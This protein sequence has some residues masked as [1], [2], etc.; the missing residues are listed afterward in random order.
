MRL[1]FII[2]GLA[3][4]AV[5]AS[6]IGLYMASSRPPPPAPPAQS[7]VMT[8]IEDATGRADE[9]D[10][11]I[12]GGEIRSDRFI[13]QGMMQTETG[14]VPF[15]GEIDSICEARD[16][17]TCWRLAELTL[18]GV[19]FR[20]T[21]RVDELAVRTSEE[22]QE[23][24]SMDQRSTGQS[25]ERSAG[26]EADESAGIW[27]TVSD[28]VFGRLSPDPSAAEALRMPRYVPLRLKEQRDAWGQFE[29]PTA[30]GGVALIW[31]EME[32]VVRK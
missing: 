19:A 26:A 17:N 10:M 2:V 14:S 28:S 22:D 6:G 30:A 31:I 29:Y 4:F 27:N 1:S 15:F 16:D 11:L 20:L 24:T 5:I 23:S 21:D 25:T 8:L 3:G 9:V 32:Q 12:V 13:I 7:I 18:N